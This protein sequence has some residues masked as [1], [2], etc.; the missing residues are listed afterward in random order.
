M[1]LLDTQRLAEV[2]QAQHRTHTGIEIVERDAHYA[3]G[4][5]GLAAVHE[6]VTVVGKELSNLLRAAVAPLRM[7]STIGPGLTW[8]YALHP[9]T[10]IGKC[11]ENGLTDVGNSSTSLQKHKAEKCQGNDRPRYEQITSRMRLRSARP[12]AEDSTDVLQHTHRPPAT[13][14]RTGQEKYAR[15][16]STS[17]L[18]STAFLPLPPEAV[19]TALHRGK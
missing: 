11:Y 6:V 1:L 17:A 8:R 7:Q 12:V 15:V 10:R 19:T 18:R 9:K 13:S 14:Q 4:I 2:C 16:Y 3:K 5:A